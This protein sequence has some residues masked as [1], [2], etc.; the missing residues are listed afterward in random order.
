MKDIETA[1]SELRKQVEI[2]E[3]K[4]PGLL[5]GLDFK[6]DLDRLIDPDNH[7]DDHDEIR[8]ALESLDAAQREA[9]DAILSEAEK[10]EREE[11][12]AEP[13]DPDLVEDPVSEPDPKGSDVEADTDGDGDGDGT[14]DPDADAEAAEHQAAVDAIADHRSALGLAAVPVDPDVETD[15]PRCTGA[16]VPGK[17]CGLC[18]ITPPVK[19]ATGIQDS[20]PWVGMTSGISQ[21]LRDI[22]AP[23]AHPPRPSL[24]MLLDAHEHQALVQGQLDPLDYT[25]IALP[26][27]PQVQI[28]PQRSGGGY[29]LGMCVQIPPGVF[30]ESRII[31]PRR[32]PLD[33][34]LGMAPSARIVV[35]IDRLSQQAR[36]QM[37]TDLATMQQLDTPQ[38]TE[39]PDERE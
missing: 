17:R 12:E 9:D 39:D 13:S 8:E 3:E 18:G 10:E 38:P 14:W 20:D 4:H 35:R 25:V 2:C 32:G 28:S 19:P 24:A 33:D 34:A 30:T 1:R 36:E 7:S 31:D 37:W 15:T 16:H 27:L 5:A 21:S 6:T 26:G 29:V 22:E 11:G 23:P